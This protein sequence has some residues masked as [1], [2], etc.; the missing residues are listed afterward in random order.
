MIVRKVIV[1]N[2]KK[3]FLDT[4]EKNSPVNFLLLPRNHQNRNDFFQ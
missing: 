1:K 3:F 2:A 4:M